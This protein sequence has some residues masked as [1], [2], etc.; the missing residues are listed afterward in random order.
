ML[1]SQKYLNKKIAIYGMGLTGCSAAKSFKKLKANVICWDDNPKIRKKAKR[2]NLSISKFWKNEKIIDFILISPG[3]NIDKCKINKY[4]KKNF[5][6]IITDLDLFF[7]FNKKSLIISITGTN[8]KS[9]TCKIIEKILKRARYKVK[10]V[11]NIGNPIL[12]TK[13]NN[14]KNILIIEVSSYQLQYSK[15]FNSSHAAIL[16]ISSDHLERHKNMKNYIKAKSK[17][18]FAQK[19]GDYSYISKTN[20]YS[21]EVK[22]NFY[23]KK[24]KS[25]LVLVSNANCKLLLKKVKNSYFKS[26]G[27]IENLSFAYKISKNLKIKDSI[28]INAINNFKG[29]PHRQEIVISNKKIL[30]IN[31]SKATSFESSQQA[32]SNNSNIYWIVGGLHKQGDNFNFK[33]A[34]KKIIR[35]Y[36]IGKKIL[37]FKKKIGKKIPYVVSNNL[38]NAVNQVFNDIKK[39][40]NIKSTILL[41]PAAASFDQFSNF[42]SRGNYFKKLISRKFKEK[43]YV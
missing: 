12:S 31:D 29:L 9:T 1:D 28:I 21:K 6:K 8:G 2:L 14:K 22:K 10:V 15:L 18:F 43:F 33:N 24:I 41:S 39:N 40:K 20:K 11:G 5:H 25:K 37:F 35:A 26:K 7:E 27:N 42:E 23:K 16:N 3:I 13:N 4:L 34:K 19:N 32:L 36:I 17:I 38:N 30:C